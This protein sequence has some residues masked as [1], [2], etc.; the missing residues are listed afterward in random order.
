METAITKEQAGIP[1]GGAT[2]EI[3][4]KQSNSDFDYDWQ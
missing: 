1:N 3:L 2:G 4:T